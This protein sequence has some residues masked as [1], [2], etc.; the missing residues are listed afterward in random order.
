MPLLVER[1]LWP[2]EH[3]TVVVGADAETRVRRL[4]DQRRLDVADVR[5][6]IARQASD[7]ERRAAADVWVD[8]DG[9]LSATEAQ[10][11]RLW[12]DRLV[13]YN[14]NLLT[15]TGS[16]RPP[17]AVVDPDASW[18]DQADRLVARVA[19][20]LTPRAVRVDHVGSTSVPNLPAKDVIDLQIGVASLADADESGF[21]ADLTERGFIRLPEMTADSPHTPDIDSAHWAKRFHVSMD[22][23]RAANIHIREI[24]SPGWRFALQFRDWLRGEPRRP[25]PVCVAEAGARGRCSQCGGVRRGQGALVRRRIRP[26][27]GLGPS[28]RVG[29]RP[30]EPG[31]YSAV[32]TSAARRAPPAPVGAEAYR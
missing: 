3:L 21:V 23:G 16:P 32:G 4:V 18:P 26:R 13:P 12:F 1:R 30:A 8:N 22:P 19:H 11:R 7:A 10:V 9:D 15:G 29:G 27:R 28:N 24:G 14:A 25:P 31:G 5:H 6:R 2:R 20:A 17:L